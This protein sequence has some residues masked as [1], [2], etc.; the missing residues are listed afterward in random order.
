VR[1]IRFV[2]CTLVVSLIGSGLVHAQHHLTASEARAH[3]G[4]TATVC[5][6]VVSTKFAAST[7]GRPTFLNLDKPYPGQIFTIVIWGEDRAKFG[8]PE[9]TY[10]GK[11]ACVTGHISE[12][13][14]IP[15]IIATDPKQITTEEK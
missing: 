9:E 1:S 7:R 10:R 8:A 13:R 12:Y 11:H 2:V 14:R 5:G 15:E 4:E 3:I 6:E